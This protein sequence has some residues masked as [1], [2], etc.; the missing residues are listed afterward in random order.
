MSIQEMQLYL[1]K[2]FDFDE[3]I[4]QIIAKSETHIPDDPI[5]KIIHLVFKKDCFA[6]GSS[7]EGAF[8]TPL[9]IPVKNKTPDLDFMRVEG[10]LSNEDASGI[11]IETEY[12]GFYRI[13]VGNPQLKKILYN[14]SKFFHFLAGD[15]TVKEALSKLNK[16]H[17]DDKNLPF[18]ESNHGCP[19][20]TVGIRD[21]F[22]RDNGGK[23]A[24]RSY[25]KILSLL[26]VDLV[27]CLRLKFWPDIASKWFE[28]KRYWPDQQTL[29][30][31]RKLGC[32]LVRKC[33]GE[34]SKTWRLSFSEAEFILANQQNSFQKKSYLLAK[35]IFT[36]ETH[37][38]VES[39]TD[40]KLCSYQLKTVFL[41]TLEKTPPEEFQTLDQTNDYL[42]LAFMML[43]KLSQALK[44]GYLPCYFVQ[45]MNL[46]YGFGQSFLDSIADR[47]DKI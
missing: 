17:K 2:F 4:S 18:L 19:S 23:N 13:D 28:R 1:D 36:L 6:S 22:L 38:L 21:Q 7:M 29:C 40:R 9:M 43:E 39:E 3:S 24:E 46:L 35:L 14:P 34:E 27:F 32:T 45:E 33:I 44:N 10:V 42:K 16:E 31:I 37:G 5:E 41:F 20:A 26:T 15:D 12:P 47:L 11:L 25:Y 8:L 30:E